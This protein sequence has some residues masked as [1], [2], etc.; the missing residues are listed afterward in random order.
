MAATFESVDA[1][2]VAADLL[3]FQGM[4]HGRAFVDHLDAS[5]LQCRHVLLWTAPC[6][7]WMMPLMHTATTPHSP[8][9]SR[10]PEWRHA[11]RRDGALDERAHLVSERISS[12]RSVS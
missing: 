4:P 10:S 11:F 1:D 5:H 12:A 7:Q 8:W 9:T 3:R 6:R 2:G